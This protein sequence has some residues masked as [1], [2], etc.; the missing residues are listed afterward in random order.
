MCILISSADGTMRID[1][2]MLYKIWYH[3]TRTLILSYSSGEK[4]VLSV[5]A[6]RIAVLT[7]L[8][9]SKLLEVWEA[10]ITKNWAAWGA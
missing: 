3:R 8:A 10:K 1:F 6:G 5:T 7:H 2:H 4:S 9:L